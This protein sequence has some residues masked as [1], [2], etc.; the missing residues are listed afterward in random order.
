[1]FSGFEWDL[2][3]AGAVPVRLTQDVQYERAD[4]GA[5]PRR[6]FGLSIL[7]ASRPLIESVLRRWVMSVRNIALRPECRVTEIVTDEGAVHGVRHPKSGQSEVLEADLVVDASGRGA[8]TFALLDSLGWERPKVTDV[9][10]DISY[11]TALVEIPANATAD[12]KLVLT[13]PDPPALAERS[14]AAD[15]GRPLDRYGRRPRREGKAGDV[16]RFPRCADP[17]EHADHLRRASSR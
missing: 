13:L 10:I 1:M 6:D 9:G 3:E 14:V 2:A 11:S 12:W 16:G 8:L 15:R 4:V 17:A 5:L 7:C